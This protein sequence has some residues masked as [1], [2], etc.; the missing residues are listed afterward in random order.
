M[1][2]FFEVQYHYYLDKATI[3]DEIDYNTIDFC[4]SKI[5]IGSIKKYVKKSEK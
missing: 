2:L 3:F 1:E 4:F 5:K